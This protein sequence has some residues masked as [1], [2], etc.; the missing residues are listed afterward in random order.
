MSKLALSV[1]E[2]A[3]LLGVSRPMVYQLIH[4]ADFPAFRIGGRVL[5]SRDLL[6]EWV[7]EQG[8]NGEA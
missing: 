5:I 8:R 7:R 2:T 3:K 4:R 1:T 6:A